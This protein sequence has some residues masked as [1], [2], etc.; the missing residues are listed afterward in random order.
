VGA[1]ASLPGNSRRIG[2]KLGRRD[3]PRHQTE[4]LRIDGGDVLVRQQ[5]L[6]SGA[7]ADHAGEPAHPAIGREAN[8][9]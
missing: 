7:H 6:L 8:C 1:S 2:S 5:H 9:G 4:R 3:D